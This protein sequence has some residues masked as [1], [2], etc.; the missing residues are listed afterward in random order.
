MGCNTL[1]LDD[2]YINRQ[3][4]QLIENR[5]K[6]EELDLTNKN[7][8]MKYLTE[9]YEKSGVETEIYAKNGATVYTTYGGQIFDFLYD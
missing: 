9:L 3:K 7:A 5:A 1:F 4:V 8:T 2:Y 6:I